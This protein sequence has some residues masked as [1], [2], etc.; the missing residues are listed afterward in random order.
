MKARQGIA[1]IEYPVRP[2][3]AVTGDELP[4][5]HPGGWSVEPKLDG[6]LN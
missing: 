5:S 3:V 2:M 1:G 6:F 4:T